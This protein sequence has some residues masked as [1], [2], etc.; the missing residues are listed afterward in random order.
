MKTICWNVK[1][2][3]N[4]NWP[5][6]A[7]LKVPIKLHHTDFH[8]RDLMTLNSWTKHIASVNADN[9]MRD[10]ILESEIY[11]VGCYRE[12]N[13]LNLCYWMLIL[14]ENMTFGIPPP[15]KLLEKTVGKI[16]S[17]NYPKC[18][19]ASK[20][21]IE[22]WKERHWLRATLPLHELF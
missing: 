20:G 6:C 3:T 8:T 12:D 16:E 11:N 17:Y 2:S 22:A 10:A 13:L 21:M 7:S 18:H 14:F 1:T 19:K 9:L 15:G 5:D 4:T